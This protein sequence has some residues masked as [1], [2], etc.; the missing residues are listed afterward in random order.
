MCL[1][2]TDRKDSPV[3]LFCGVIRK[4]L[5]TKAV[6]EFEVAGPAGTNRYFLYDV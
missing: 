6:A 1:V 5:Q 2:F 3:F 4:H